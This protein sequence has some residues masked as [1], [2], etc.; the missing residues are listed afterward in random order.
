MKHALDQLVI[1]PRNG[2][3]N[4]LQ[5]W[6]SAVI[7]GAQL[8]TP[9]SVVWEPERIAPAQALD[10]FSESAVRR[11]FW[12][13][14]QV[15]SVVGG[16]HQDLP[17]YLTLDP[18]R[19]IVVLAGH[20][21]G[22][23]AF[24]GELLSALAAPCEPTSLV[25]I[26]GG[27]FHLDTHEDFDRQR[28]VFYEAVPWRADIGDAVAAATHERSP[29][30]GLHVRG[31]DRSREAP[32]AHAVREALARL[33]ELGPT[34][35]FIAADTEDARLR[36]TD[37]ALSLGFEPWSRASV[38]RDRTVVAEGVDAVIDWRVLGKAQAIV[39]AASSSF[40]A[41]AAVCTAQPSACIALTASPSRQRLRA[42]GDWATAA[43]TYPRRR[44]RS[45]GSA[46]DE[47]VSDIIATRT[48]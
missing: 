27:K 12:D 48:Q 33:K 43:V 38:N 32:P 34:S 16:A 40:G 8:D 24:M 36:W 28:R 17:R 45:A 5:A 4:R 47:S 23:Q 9:V 31:T 1:V 26:A 21:R 42:A 14:E 18:D 29:Y 15:T 30:V 3:V 11:T 25:V 39:H 10:L 7:L 20:D 19:R 46:G 6:A 2:Y 41:E 44:W 37:E 13:V 22:E 35:L